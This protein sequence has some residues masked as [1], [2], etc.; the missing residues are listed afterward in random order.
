MFNMCLLGVM[1]DAF[2][3]PA[4]YRADMACPANPALAR[5][6]YLTREDSY[7]ARV[8]GLAGPASQRRR[9]A[10]SWFL[11]IVVKNDPKDKNAYPSILDLASEAKD[12]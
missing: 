8:S 7:R 11:L 12:N 6:H 2:P 1:V 4:K 3:A 5:G 9:A 10:D